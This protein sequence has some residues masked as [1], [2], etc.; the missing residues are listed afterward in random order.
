LDDESLISV[1]AHALR[2]AGENI[3]WRTIDV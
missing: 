3:D 2:G 1:E